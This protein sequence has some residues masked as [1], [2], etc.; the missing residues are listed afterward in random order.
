[1][2]AG[3]AA[4]TTPTPPT[5]TPLPTD[6]PRITCPAPQSIVAATGQSAADVAYPAPTI[7]GGAS[8]VSFKCSPPTTSSFAIGSTSV[9]CMATDAQQRADSCTFA[10]TVVPPPPPIPR[11]SSTKFVCFGD[12]MTEGLNPLALP[13]F[14]PNPRGSYPADLQTLL[15]GRYSAQ[16]ISVLDEGIGGE[17][18]ATGM[19]RLPGVLS[20]DRPDAL[21]LLEGVNDLNEFG[22]SAIPAVISGLRAMVKQA[23]ASGATVFLATLPPQR[24]GASRAFSVALVQPTDD[25]IRALASAEGAVLV[26]VFRDFNGEV[27]TLLGDDG[28][29]PNA[30]GYQ[31]MAGSFFAAI[32]DTLEISR[33]P[34]VTSSSSVPAL[35]TGVTAPTRALE[36]AHR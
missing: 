27:G 7:V 14:I 32:R 26:D 1:M 21:L 33:V 28:L 3:C 2:T 4:S 30:A 22:A 29:H 8:P 11:I 12:S 16:S 18:V 34:T 15:S 31:R 35:R 19:R 6:P 9:R 17:P 5:P 10:V 23:R 13:T 36:N 24:A 20:S 25:Q